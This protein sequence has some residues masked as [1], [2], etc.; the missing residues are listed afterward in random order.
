MELHLGIIKSENSSLAKQV[1]KFESD[2]SAQERVKKDLTD[3]RELRKKQ[4]DLNRL[5]QS[6][7]MMHTN[8]K[9]MNYENLIA[10]KDTLSKE[11]SKLLE[12]RYQTKGSRNEIDRTIKTLEA[13]LKHKD[14]ADAEKEFQKAC[15]DLAVRF[16]IN[17][18]EVVSIF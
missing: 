13:E 3:N 14:C 15:T 16:W 18:D 4:K 1:Q 7:A 6:Y 10:E 12:N 5:K 2:F 8:V 11:K 9:S 17:N